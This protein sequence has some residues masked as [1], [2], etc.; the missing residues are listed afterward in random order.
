MVH[1]VCLCVYACMLCMFVGYLL[2][3][4]LQHN[5]VKPVNLAVFL[6]F[7]CLFFLT[8]CYHSYCS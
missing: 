2:V 7:F 1:V 4:Y 8:C 5:F 3:G 6:F